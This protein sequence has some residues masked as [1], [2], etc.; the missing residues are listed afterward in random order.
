MKVTKIAGL[1]G[2]TVGI[3]SASQIETKAASDWIFNASDNTYFMTKKTIHTTNGYFKDTPVTIPKGTIF[4][5]NGINRNG[6]SGLP[7]LEINTSELSW[8]VRKTLAN[9]KHNQMLTKGIWAKKSNFKIVKTP[10][11]LEFYDN[12]STRKENP[13]IDGMVT[14][15]KGSK[16]VDGTTYET[17][18]IKV[19]T[20]GYLEYTQ[21]LG[22]YESSDG[23]PIDYA[24]IRHTVNKNGKVYYYYNS[25]ISG[26]PAT[27]LSGKYK[28]RTTIK[29]TKI[30]R[31][32][33]VPGANHY[34]GDDNYV[35]SNIY[36]IG[37]Q[38]FYTT[39]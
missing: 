38:T 6:K 7:F 3:I 37:G 15:W 33:I 24:K 26:I 18:Q 32:T 36:S 30:K 13:Y 12:T 8:P 9:S 2:I 19:T 25:K 14:F 39:G 28:Y 22:T 23:Q 17:N 35:V 31:V 4:Q 1:L 21:P 10:A 29:N 16:F 20:D 11:Y 34:I 5:Y 27:K